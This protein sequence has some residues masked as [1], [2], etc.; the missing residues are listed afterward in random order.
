MTSEDCLNFSVFS[1]VGISLS[2]AKIILKIFDSNNDHRSTKLSRLPTVHMSSAC[3][4]P[5]DLCSSDHLLSLHSD[6]CGHFPLW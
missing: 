2:Q 4:H 5:K 6:L 1:I 3:W